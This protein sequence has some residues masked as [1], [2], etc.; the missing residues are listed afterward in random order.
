MDDFTLKVIPLLRDVGFPVICLYYLYKAY[1]DRVS[2]G[3][4]RE[5]KYASVIENH[6]KDCSKLALALNDLATEIRTESSIR[7]DLLSKLV[8]NALDKN[9]SI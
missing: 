6:S 3:D 2:Q 4:K 9:K 7:Q 8:Q 5:D 1:L